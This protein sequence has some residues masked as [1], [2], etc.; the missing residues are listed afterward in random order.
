MSVKTRIYKV[1]EKS[2]G[3]MRIVEAAT[4]PIVA[5][6]IM[7]ADYSITV[8]RDAVEVTKLVAEYGKPEVAGAK[9]ETI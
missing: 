6:H 8:V 4:V 3:K 7:E 2:T 1:L 9:K 5:R